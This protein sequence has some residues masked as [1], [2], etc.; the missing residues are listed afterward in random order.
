MH[1]G[2]AMET[3]FFRLLKMSKADLSSTQPRSAKWMTCSSWNIWAGLMINPMPSRL[4]RN[5]YQ[6]VIQ[7]REATQVHR[8]LPPTI[9]GITGRKNQALRIARL[10]WGRWLIR[11]RR[12]VH[13][14][15]LNRKEVTLRTRKRRSLINL[16]R[17][18]C[19]WRSSPLV[20]NDNTKGSYIFLIHKSL[21]ISILA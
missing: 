17:E 8:R 20:D 4:L 3:S 16:P 12:R 6:A 15:I 1:R 7:H 11:A 18:R 13:R 5:D 2:R 9:R 21:L 19:S 14:L 10:H